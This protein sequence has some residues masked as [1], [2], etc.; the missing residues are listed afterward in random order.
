M[1]LVPDAGEARWTKWIAIAAAPR[2]P[3]SAGA[4]PGTH[5]ADWSASPS[6]CWTRLT[7]IACRSRHSSL[8]VQPNGSVSRKRSSW[9]TGRAHWASRSGRFGRR[10]GCGSWPRCRRHGPA[11]ESIS[12]GIVARKPC[13]GWTD[14]RRRASI[15]AATPRRC[16]SRR[17]AA[18]VSPSTSKLPAMACSAPS[19]ATRRA[20]R[21][22]L[23]SCV[24]LIPRSGRSMSITTSFASSK[25]TAIL[26]A[27]PGRTAASARSRNRH[28]TG[29]GPAGC[30]TTS[31]ASAILP[32][33]MIARHGP[34]REILRDLLA[35]RNGTVAHELSAV[36]HAHLD[37]AWLWPL[38]ET[39]RKAQRSFSTA[40]ALMER[41]PDFQIRLLAGLSI[42]RH[43]TERSRPVRA[44]PRQGSRRTM[45]SRG[46]QLDRAGLQPAVGRVDLPPVP[47]WS[48]LLRAH[49]R[50]TL[51]RV[52]ESG[53]V[54]L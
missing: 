29:H 14:A 46:R 10:I 7:P 35:A 13:F 1:H 32:I 51:D 26:R 15:P 45:D 6:G 36:G 41:Y 8:P 24:A 22:R 16:Y 3:G 50:T 47:L 33:P 40:V 19:A 43:R 18:S 20:T 34:R 38:D 2:S 28:W 54:R 48:A 44:Y 37:T 30:C 25:P 5:A 31:T 27:S 11:Q 23:A 9:T 42:R 17:R 39:R 52:L 21:W 12:I 53:C 49:L 4:T